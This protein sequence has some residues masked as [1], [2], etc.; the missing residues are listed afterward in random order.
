MCSI[1]FNP[2]IMNSP[3]SLPRM[4][5]NTDCRPNKFKKYHD[6]LDTHR[7]SR[8][9]V[10]TPDCS[11]DLNRIVRGKGNFTADR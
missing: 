6:R 9:R 3:L 11:I 5:P 2:N 1:S 10:M 7:T 4:N 8:S